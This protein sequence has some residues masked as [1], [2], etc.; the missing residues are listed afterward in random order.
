MKMVKHVRG[1]IVIHQSVPFIGSLGLH[2]V[3]LDQDTVPGACW[4]SKDEFSP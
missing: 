2:K 1:W 3:W 4:R